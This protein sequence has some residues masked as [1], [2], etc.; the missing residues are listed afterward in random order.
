MTA[1]ELDKK[2]VKETLSGKK[3]LILPMPLSGPPH[4]QAR[5]KNQKILRYKSSWSA[6]TLSF[7]YQSNIHLHQVHI[8]PNIRAAGRTARA[9]KHHRLKPRSKLQRAQAP[10]V[11]LVAIVASH[12]WQAIKKRKHSNVF[13]LFETRPWHWSVN[14]LLF[15]NSHKKLLTPTCAL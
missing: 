1:N 11:R 9:E 5:Q 14:I 13:F 4:I 12:T 10:P 7:H 2:V 8:A 15:C 6:A 3:F